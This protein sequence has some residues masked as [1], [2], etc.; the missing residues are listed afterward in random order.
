LIEY[1]LC[2]ILES[3]SEE[4]DVAVLMVQKGTQVKKGQE[5]MEI[6]TDK[7]AFVVE[8]PEDGVSRAKTLCSPWLRLFGAKRWSEIYVQSQSMV[9]FLC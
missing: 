4:A 1:R 2:D 8:A 9:N 5:L 3:E 6:A 7:A